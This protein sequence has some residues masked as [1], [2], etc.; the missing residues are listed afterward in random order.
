M[1]GMR[2][3]DWYI[4]RSFLVA[5]LLWTV[6]LM[7]LR[8]VLDLLANMDE[9]AELGTIAEVLGGITDYYGLHLTEYVA[10]LGG[11]IIVVSA[12]FTLA[13]MN[14]TN[15]LTAM[16]AS[17]MSLHRVVWPIIICAA[18]LGGVLVVDQ[19]LVIPS[20]S[21]ELVRERD[22]SDA[23]RSTERVNLVRDGS[24][25]WHSNRF[26]LA[27]PAME[28][29]LFIVRN[30]E[31]LPVAWAYCYSRAV[32]VPP[33]ELKKLPGGWEL[34]AKAKL[35]CWRPA[36]I[37]SQTTERVYTTRGP[38]AVLATVLADA[39]EA[40]KPVPDVIHDAGWYSPVIDDLYDME[41]TAD[42]A[43]FE[44][45]SAG[46]MAGGRLR[47]PQFRIHVRLDGKLE[48]FGIILADE[49][50]YV[51]GDRREHS[52]WRLTGGKIRIA[53]DMTPTDLVMQ[54]VDNQTEYLSSAQLNRLLAGGWV[55][56]RDGTELTKWVR[57]ADP[58]TNLVMLLLGLP[59]ILSR[60][61]N[62]KVSF[63]L[64]LL[65]V[66]AFFAFTHICRFMG[67]QPFW[68]AFLPIMLFSPVSVVMLDSVKT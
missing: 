35:H 22:G 46:R 68:R 21:D 34:E 56:D 42:R 57:I 26:D 55:R 49:A 27:I 1:T 8:V 64:C 16:L 24:R 37:M 29:P 65:M 18:L 20:L 47:N 2:T 3:I 41:L 23:G 14:H 4:V 32:H 63:G 39:R 15:E 19:E 48:L 67:I 51:I 25:V 12:A 60:E 13:R 53:S 11:V 52:H 10:Q 59:F 62:I 38:E 17:G 30:S 40:N 7:T 28:A 44:Y 61:R 54:Q 9:F 43:F 36:W 58:I 66:G 6:S 5:V 33:D 45:D 31:F 50:E